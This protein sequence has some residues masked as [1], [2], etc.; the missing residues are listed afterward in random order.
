M[1]ALILDAGAGPGDE[2][3]TSDPGDL[4][5]LCEAT[6]IKAVAVGCWPGGYDGGVRQTRARQWRTR[7]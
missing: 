5:K 1:I 7:R 2:P 6:G 4:W 3:Y